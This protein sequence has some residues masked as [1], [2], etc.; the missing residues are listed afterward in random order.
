MCDVTVLCYYKSQEVS[1]LVLFWYPINVQDM[2]DL[3]KI[4]IDWLSISL[5]PFVCYVLT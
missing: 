5:E 3:F 4:F 1:Q 2:F